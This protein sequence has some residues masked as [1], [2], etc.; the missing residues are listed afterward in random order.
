[1]NGSVINFITAAEREQ[2][3]IGLE[4]IQLLYGRMF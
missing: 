4:A 2:Y 3:N 1:M